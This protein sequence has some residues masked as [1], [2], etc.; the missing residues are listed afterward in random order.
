MKP[1]ILILACTIACTGCTTLALERHTLSQGESVAALRA[2]EV[3]D[4]LALVA[5][6]PAGLPAYSSIFAGTAQ[7]TDSAQFGATFLW[8]VK[9]VMSSSTYGL[10]S[11]AANMQLSRSVSQNWSLD[12]LVVPEKVEAMRCACRWVVCGP[13]KACGSCPGL[14]ASPEQDH[15]PGRHFGVEERLARLPPCWLHIG[16]C[17]EVPKAAR[18]KAHCGAT[19]VWVMPDGLTGLADFTLVLQDIARIHINSESLFYWPPPPCV[20]SRGSG[21]RAAQEGDKAIGIDNPAAKND[22]KMTAIAGPATLEVSAYVDRNQHLVPVVPYRQVRFE[23]LGSD[24]SIRSQV[25]AAGAP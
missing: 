5:N 21:N 24:P 6:D 17:A 4:N 20:Y 11:E 23:N 10:F 19:W 12:P 22:S 2:Q 13:E 8:L 18:Y 7:V 9:G 3:L 15:S 1:W 16:R 14:L 25:S